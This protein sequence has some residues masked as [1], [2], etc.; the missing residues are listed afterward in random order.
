MSNTFQINIRTNPIT[1][2]I[3]L[4]PDHPPLQLLPTCLPIGAHDR[5]DFHSY[6][7]LCIRE[8][9]HRLPVIIIWISFPL[10]CLSLLLL[11][12]SFKSQSLSLRLSVPHD[13]DGSTS[14]SS[15]AAHSIFPMIRLLWF[16]CVMCKWWLSMAVITSRT[17]SRPLVCLSATTQAH[18]ILCMLDQKRGQANARHYLNTFVYQKLSPIRRRLLHLL[19]ILESGLITNNFYNVNVTCWWLPKRRRNPTIRGTWWSC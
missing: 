19:F 7:S 2:F 5:W 6:S 16:L 13:G 4:S 1:C 18:S 14:S 12:Q 9:N 17:S 11:Y 15:A 3:C 8:T 10:L